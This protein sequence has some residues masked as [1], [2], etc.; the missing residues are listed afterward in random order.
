M[1]PT[2]RRIKP[3]IGVSAVSSPLEV[4]AN[5]ALPSAQDLARNLESAGCEIIFFDPISSPDQAVTAGRRW[6]E[7]R[8]DAIALAAACWFEDY[9]ILDLLEECRR[10]LLLRPLP[11]MET[12]ALCGCQQA[13]AFLK[14]LDH[15]YL[16]VFGPMNDPAV[17]AQSVPFCQG[18]ALQT[19]LR[20]S[21]IGIAGHHL[22]GMT[23]TAPQEFLLKKAFGSRVVWLDLPGL[24]QQAKDI[25]TAPLEAQ[26]QVLSRK[27]G[28]CDVTSAEGR[29]SL[30]VYQ[31][32]RKQVLEQGLDA[33]T[34]GCYPQLMGRVC[35][36][37]SLLADDGIPFACEGDVHGALGLLMLQL[38]SGEPG[39][40][41]DWLDPVDESSVVFTHCGSG[42]WSLAEKPETIRLAS[43]RL[44]G[45]GVCSLFTAKPG[46][47]TLVNITPQPDAYLCGILEGIAEPTE[48]VFPG[49]PVRVRF[50]QPVAK[51]IPWIHETGLGHHWM[52]GYGHHAR[53]LRAWAKLAGTS[54]RVVEAETP[55]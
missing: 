35:L 27:A 54:L 37:A 8:V 15:P 5:R 18:A 55:T 16:S 14:A 22:T 48:M 34:V 47:V 7:T 30:Q 9:L 44:M 49:N 23:H 43:V 40:S 19:R 11:G 29:D 26:W 13:T 32:L 51:L 24:L 42:S 36:A 3:R 52:I 21:R 38:L 12:G 6:A 2:T 46:P 10:P 45:Q 31:S 33:V 50:G 25:P 41:T 4:G 28:Q 17:L 39:H 1:S 53:A 20:R